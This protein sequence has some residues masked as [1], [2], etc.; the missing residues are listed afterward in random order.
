MTS[1]TAI[2]PVENVL[3][4]E[5]KAHLDRTQPKTLPDLHKT[6]SYWASIDD[7]EAIDVCLATSLDRKVPGDPVWVM[8]ITPSGGFKSELLQALSNALPEWTHKI[9]GLT[10]RSIVSGRATPTGAEV[11]GLAVEADGKVVVIKDFTEILSK[12]RTERGEIFGQL[13]NWYDGEI[14]RRFGNFDKTLRVKS[15]IGLIMGCVP[16]VDRYTAMLGALGERFLKIRYTQ[17]RNDSLKRSL[18]NLALEREMR[19][20]LTCALQHYFKNLEINP[21]TVSQPFKE[22]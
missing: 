1:E 12:E 11:K 21:P 22:R 10:S 7:F 6:F 2:Q 8:L 15:S 4:S 9:D 19:Q 3:K 13:R 14:S 5:L 16:S 17:N 20:E 18:D